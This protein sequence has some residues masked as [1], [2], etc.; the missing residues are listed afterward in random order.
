MPDSP[1]NFPAAPWVIK[2]QVPDEIFTDRQEFLEYF[3]DAARKAADRRTMSTVLLG[4]R[5]MGKTEIFQLT[6]LPV[7]FGANSV[8]RSTAGSS[9]STSMASPSGFV[10]TTPSRA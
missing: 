8:N 5:R 2:P 4:Q 10:T 6:S 7:L 1:T 3:Y 9:V